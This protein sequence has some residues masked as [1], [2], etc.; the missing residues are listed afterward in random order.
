[1]PSSAQRRTPDP[2]YSRK[3]GSIRQRSTMRRQLRTQGSIAL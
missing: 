1:M 2:Q 3:V